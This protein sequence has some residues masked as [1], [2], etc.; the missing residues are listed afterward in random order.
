MASA[1]LAEIAS[2]GQTFLDSGNNDARLKAIAAASAL[3]QELEN[4]G[5]QMA[6]IG[7]GEPTRTAALRTAFELGVLKRLGD[8]PQSSE[9]LARGTKADPPLVGKLPAMFGCG[10]N[11]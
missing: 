1:I 7:W 2:N 5:E 10:N 4:P 6:R 8:E 3:I 9:E 11:G